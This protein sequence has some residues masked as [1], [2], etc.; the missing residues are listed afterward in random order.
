M[1][2]NH[3]DTENPERPCGQER[4]NPPAAVRPWRLFRPLP[5]VLSV[6]CVSVVSI[7]PLTG[8]TRNGEF[9]AISM[10]N[11]SRLKPL[12][13]SPI[14]GEGSSS[15]PLPP[16][17]VARGMLAADDPVNT[18]RANGRL[19]TRIPIPVNRAVLERGQERFNIYCSPCHSRIGDGQGM[20]VQRG[21]PHPPDYAIPRIRNAPVGHFF[22]VMT[23]G[24]GVM[25]SYASRVA[26]EDRWA[27]AAYIRVLQA[28]RPVV[29]VDR[30]EQER[31]RARLSGI[32]T[33]PVGRGNSE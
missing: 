24:Y 8:C 26:P 31:I 29:P 16:G 13:E 20:I 14:P 9:Q 33:R 10:W 11:D 1:G 32:G 4:S 6:L 2:T 15:R 30:Y 25:Y 5:S 27:I 17:T 19:V 7:M 21:F 3:R 28:S 12:E 22:D 18:A 23:N